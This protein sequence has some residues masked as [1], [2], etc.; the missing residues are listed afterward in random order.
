MTAWGQIGTIGAPVL[1]PYQEITRKGNIPSFA[2]NAFTVRG[3]VTVLVPK[4]RNYNQDHAMVLR[5]KFRDKRTAGSPVAF[6]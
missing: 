6:C 5:F 2:R 1:V 4:L 3:T